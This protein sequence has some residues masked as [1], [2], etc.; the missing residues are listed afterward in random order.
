MYIIVVQYS[1]RVVELDADE[2]A[3]IYINLDGIHRT[4]VSDYYRYRTGDTPGYRIS[5][6]GLRFASVVVVVV[7]VAG[8]SRSGSRRGDAFVNNIVIFISLALLL[9]PLLLPL[10]CR[11]D[12]IRRVILVVVTSLL[13]IIHFFLAVESNYYVR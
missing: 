1:S 13:I 3:C 8:N 4:D 7:A 10:R 5:C 12:A 2:A 6:I 11:L 9:L